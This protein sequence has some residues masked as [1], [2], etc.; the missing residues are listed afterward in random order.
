MR[1]TISF[2]AEVDRVND[3]M[4][5]LAKQET[6]SIR[7][8]AHVIETA[9]PHQIHE[10]INVALEGLYKNIN[11]LEQYR[12]ML[13]GFEKAKFETRLPQTAETPMAMNS[14]SDVRQVTQNMQRFDS[15]LGRIN[16]ES[17][18]DVAAQE[19]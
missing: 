2:E 13:L 16:E 7:S 15:F 10:K 3:V 17:I 11:Q 8:S 18:D 12:D 14:A 6:D 4:V 19:G 5:A 1:A 9:Q